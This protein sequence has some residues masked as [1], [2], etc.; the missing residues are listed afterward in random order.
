[1]VAND[2]ECGEVAEFAVAVF[3][4]AVDDDFDVVF[5]DVAAFDVGEGAAD[6]FV[7]FFCEFGEG[8]E[9]ETHR[10]EF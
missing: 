3:A 5:G 7:I 4:N 10:S 9:E 8:I 6:A 2:F 1:M